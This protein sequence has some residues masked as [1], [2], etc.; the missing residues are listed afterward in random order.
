MCS[1]HLGADFVYAWPKSEIA[2]MGAEGALEILYAKQMKDPSQA[3]FV[4]EKSAEYRETV[5]NPKI[6]AAHDYISEIIEP[7]Q[8]R[9]YVA[10]SLEF[11]ENK[12]QA[13]VPAKKHGNIP[14]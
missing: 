8:T 12:A 9:E 14:L 7:G 3:A 10:S 11:L 2:V 4:A 6:A 1:K 5:M 13:G